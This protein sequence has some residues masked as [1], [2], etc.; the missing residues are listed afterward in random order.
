ML[1]AM[2]HRMLTLLAVALSTTGCAILEGDPYQLESL[3][4]GTP[5]E[6]LFTVDSVSPLRGIAVDAKQRFVWSPHIN[7]RT[8]AKPDK[9]GNIEPSIERRAILCA[10][11]SPD[12][13]TA[14]ANTID[15]E[16]RDKS[17][18]TG[19]D[20]AETA[21]KLAGSL[22]ETAETIGNR[23]QVIQLLRDGFYRACEAYANGAL[24]DFGYSMVLSHIDLFM[25]QL[26]SADALGRAQGRQDVAEKTA[27]RDQKLIRVQ[28]VNADFERAK[29]ALSRL[30]AQTRDIA[31]RQA[32]L[33]DL[34][35]RKSE[36]EARK[37]TLDSTKQTLEGSPTTPGSIAHT[38]TQ[39]VSITVA[40]K[41]AL[42]EEARYSNLQRDADNPEHDKETK[43]AKQKAADAARIIAQTMR[44]DAEVKKANQTFLKNKFSKDDD[45]LRGIRRQLANLA[46]EIADIESQIDALMNQTETAPP[47]PDVSVA[48]DEVTKLQTQVD[49]A[50]SELAMAEAALARALDGTGP[51]P[52]E[53]RAL[54]K[55]LEQTFEAEK[56]GGGPGR[57]SK[58]A[59]LQWFAKNPHIKMK[60]TTTPEAPYMFSSDKGIPAIAA[61]CKSILAFD[62]P[63]KDEKSSHNTAAEGPSADT[64]NR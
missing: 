61:I 30:R 28:K 60:I 4:V 29:Q 49:G 36:L 55:L 12:V 19:G 38:R 21:A 25:L 10:E 50:Q 46:G 31:D 64:A 22:S 17:V 54:E 15:I 45:E 53:V 5:L 13:L 51:G 44:N 39:L 59:C 52:R 1:K 58:A 16:L 42:D 9:D 14:I 8:I 43:A 7:V 26:L 62:Q 24:D 40:E 33:T 11:P 32:R 20:S 63:D 37:Q 34:N 41:T 47:A 57:V 2:L 3:T 23:T 18:R 27:L 6:R 48:L 56:G 35:A